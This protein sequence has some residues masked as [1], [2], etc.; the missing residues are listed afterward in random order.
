MGSVTG[1]T[2][3]PGFPQGLRQFC[4]SSSSVLEQLLLFSTHTIRMR[5]SRCCSIILRIFRSIIPEFALPGKSSSELSVSIREFISTEVLKACI[6]SLNE[7]Y[8]VDVQRDIQLVISMILVHY[9]PLTRTPRQIMSSLPGITEA[10]VDTCIDNISQ[11]GC[12]QKVQRAYVGVLLQ[13]LKGVSISE[14]GKIAK[15]SSSRDKKNLPSKMQQ[16][17]LKKARDD[18][19]SPDLEGVADMFGE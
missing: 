13:D 14:Q 5:D 8:F 18:R 7:P 2:P 3:P 11:P 19:K 15:S 16:Q 10:A 6:S 4:L 9:S 1:T 17:F 12:N